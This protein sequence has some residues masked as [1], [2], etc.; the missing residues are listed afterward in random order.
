MKKSSSTGGYFTYEK[1]AKEPTY[2]KVKDGLIVSWTKCSERNYDWIWSTFRPL[3]CILVPQVCAAVVNAVA[4]QK[5]F[6]KINGGLPL[7]SNAAVDIKAIV[8][9][10]IKQH[11]Q[12]FL[13][14]FFHSKVTL[15]CSVHSQKSAVHLLSI[16]NKILSKET[17][18]WDKPTRTTTSHKILPPP[19]PARKAFHV[20]E[21]NQKAAIIPPVS[22]SI[23]GNI[24]HCAAQ[25][26]F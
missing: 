12:C 24:F 18:S 15:C 2:L 21:L 5:L 4:L 10:N 19:L 23:S 26:A 17:F 9:S 14:P 20:P 8:W 16:Q 1:E 7:W 6:I 22:W 3:L 11:S 13:F 25:L